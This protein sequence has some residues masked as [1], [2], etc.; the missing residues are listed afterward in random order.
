M[1]TC[2][3]TTPYCYLIG[4]SDQNTFY[5][6]VKFGKGADPKTFWVK[7]F[8]SSKVVK[9]FRKQ[10]GDP[11]IIQIRKIFRTEDYGALDLAQKASIMYEHK[12][13]K[14]FGM[15]HDARFL[16]CHTH[17]NDRTDKQN[18]NHVKYRRLLFDGNYVSADALL[19]IREKNRIFS[20]ANNPMHVASVKETHRNSMARKN[21][22][23]NFDE[24]LQKV[25]ET[26]CEMQTIKQTADALGH[27]QYAIRQLLFK[28][29]G[30]D[31]VDQIRVHG[32]INS[33]KRSRQTNRNRSKESA[34]G[35][36]NKNSKVWLAQNK[37]QQYLIFGNRHDFC[38]HMNI[39]KTLA[40]DKLHLRK[41]WSF[42]RL[43]AVKDFDQ[44]AH[45]F[46]NVSRFASINL[47]STPSQ[48]PVLR[49][50]LP[51]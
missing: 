49:S 2:F 45:K 18:V 19:N 35:R 32:L 22:Y 24:Y 48:K 31:W 29:K 10:Y 14:R 11:D 25:V 7:Y 9:K 8:T 47:K 50:T 36:N 1:R 27:C 3:I 41:G 16:N 38:D 40:S 23:Q 15:V 26:F 17:S 34:A 30:K 39:S 6:G 33:K 28:W 21:G 46:Y 5:Y 4:W 43:C 44:I 37:D 20:K 51:L 13:I 42:E 12:V